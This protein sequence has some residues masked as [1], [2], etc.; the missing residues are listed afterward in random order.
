MT[1][2]RSIRMTPEL[3]S[4]L[5]QRATAH[6]I[7]GNALATK[8]LDEGLRVAEHPGVRFRPRISDTRV[9]AVIVDQMCGRSFGSST[10]S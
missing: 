2:P 3:L 4:R 9:A 10:P 5:Q 7:S 1:A 6:G 8:L